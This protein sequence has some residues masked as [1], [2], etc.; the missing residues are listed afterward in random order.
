V[1]S[2]II[3]GKNN[4]Y[5][6][7][8][9]IFEK[10]DNLNN[11][12]SNDIKLDLQELTTDLNLAYACINTS[13]YKHILHNNI[14]LERLIS[15]DNPTNYLDDELKQIL[16]DVFAAYI[17][18]SLFSDTRLNTFYKIKVFIIKT[19]ITKTFIL[20]K[21]QFNKKTKLC[22][23]C[24]QM[25]NSEQQYKNHSIGKKHLNKLSNLNLENNFNIDSDYDNESDNDNEI[26]S[27]N[28]SISDSI[29]EKNKKIFNKASSSTIPNG[30]SRTIPNGNSRTSKTSYTEC[31]IQDNS[32]R[33]ESTKVLSSGG[34]WVEKDKTNKDLYQSYFLFNI[35]LNQYYYCVLYEFNDEDFVIGNKKSTNCW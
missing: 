11:F 21:N 10:E 28:E 4:I 13:L 35:K 3:L 30:N 29:I 8:L 24:N 18:A 23:I 6:S 22:R 16:A 15:S 1:I 33:I 12:I 34:L 27:D 26:E 25:F 9:I 7:D 19:L 20:Q 5:T 32:K 31:N 2:E 17:T 14:K